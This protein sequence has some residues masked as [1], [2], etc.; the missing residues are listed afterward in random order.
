MR[1][2]DYRSMSSLL[3]RTW[4]SSQSFI[5]LFIK[6]Q[7][8]I[9]CCPSPFNRSNC[10]SSNILNF[11]DLFLA[12]LRFSETSKSYAD[13]HFLT[14][15]TARPKKILAKLKLI[16]F[17]NFIFYMIYALKMWLN[18][19]LLHIHED[20]SVNNFVHI[21][22]LV[23]LRIQSILQYETTFASV[24]CIYICQILNCLCQYTGCKLSSGTP[25]FSIFLWICS[26]FTRLLCIVRKV[27]T[28][29]G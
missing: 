21:C 28:F 5:D 2:P 10:S 26:V 6:H 29:I 15:F 1:D 14:Y 25:I 17:Q 8:F 19:P 27:G 7:V 9:I 12:F 13:A 24:G 16:W 18:K 23:L 22:R 20:R 11:E 3:I 4:N